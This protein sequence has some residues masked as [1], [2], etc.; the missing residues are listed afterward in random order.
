MR[1][2]EVCS[3]T[4]TWLPLQAS[5][6]AE[7]LSQCEGSEEL[8]PRENELLPSHTGSLVP[9]VI[10][11]PYQMQNVQALDTSS[12]T[13]WLMRLVIQQAATLAV[14]WLLMTDISQSKLLMMLKY[15]HIHM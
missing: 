15:T 9:V 8:A 2:Q 7:H 12:F 6:P 4:Q 5:L 11:L 1:I 14:P 10:G 3:S 13:L